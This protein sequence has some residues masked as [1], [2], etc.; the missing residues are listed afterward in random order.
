MD[1]SKLWR[2]T[3]SGNRLSRLAEIRGGEKI[4]MGG[5]CVVSEKCRLV[6]N[7]NMQN[8]KTEAISMGLFCI[9]EELCLLE[10]PEV[11]CKGK[12]HESVLSKIVLHKTLTL[13]S[14]VLIGHSSEIR[15]RRIGRRVIVGSGCTLSPGCELGDV[16]IV[17]PN[18]TVPKLCKVP[19]FTRVQKH[20][21]FKGSVRFIPLPGSLRK[22]IE[23]WC[24][25]AYWGIPVDLGEILSDLQHSSS[26]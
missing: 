15:C 2:D 12:D 21:E 7:V 18:V 1:Y 24:K 13:G 23:N 14:F 4:V 6:G 25:E 19:H 9:L 3:K 10:P 17:E 22:S 26:P 11:A 5:M 16:V 20:P 8:E